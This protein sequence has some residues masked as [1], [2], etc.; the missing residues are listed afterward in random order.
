[1][2][3]RNFMYYVWKVLIILVFLVISSWSVFAQDASDFAD[4]TATALTLFLAAIAFLY[5]VGETLPKISYLTLLDKFMLN[6]FLFIFLTGAESFLVFLVAKRG[7]VDEAERIDDYCA[8]WMPVVYLGSTFFQLWHGIHFRWKLMTDKNSEEYLAEIGLES[9]M[10]AKDAE[11]KAVEEAPKPAP[12]APTTR[13]RVR[14]SIIDKLRGVTDVRRAH[15]LYRQLS[16][17]RE[18][19]G[20]HKEREDVLSRM[21]SMATIRTLVESDEDEDVEEYVDEEEEKAAAPAAAKASPPKKKKTTKKATAA[22][23]TAKTKRALLA[24]LRSG[25]LAK[26]VDKMEADEEKKAGN[27]RQLVAL[28]LLSWALW[29]CSQNNA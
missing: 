19:E 8:I 7:N 3:H 25:A 13:R 4:R 24:G 23:A 6:A 14:S 12:P 27:P 5:V 9:S 26:A 22:A 1:M 2:V 11:E 15:D 28:G 18:P 10:K 17:A 29:Q 21:A 20:R 16:E